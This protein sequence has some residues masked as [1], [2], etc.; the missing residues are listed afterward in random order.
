MSTTSNMVV[1]LLGV[2]AIGGA[3][4]QGNRPPT[5]VNVVN[6]PTVNVASLPAV[7]VSS[8]PAVQIQDNREQVYFR[9]DGSSTSLVHEVPSEEQYEVP[10]G[11][12]LHIRHVSATVSTGT[13]IEVSFMSIRA[14]KPNLAVEVEHHLNVPR[15]SSLT[16]DNRM[17]V[18]T[19]EEMDIVAEA[20][21]KVAFGLGR[22]TAF[23]GSPPAFFNAHVSGYL[24]DA[25]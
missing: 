22:T 21:D 24:T 16:S 9:F 10:A 13:G 1:G 17:L 20:G 3:V 19:S 8:L 6:T 5:D 23:V 14:L 2:A 25:P 18:S 7:Q 12:R 15:P 11:K 4:V